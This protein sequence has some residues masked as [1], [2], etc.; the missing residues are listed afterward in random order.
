MFLLSSNGHVLCLSQGYESRINV[1]HSKTEMIEQVCDS[2]CA[3]SIA[4]MAFQPMT[5]YNWVICEQGRHGSESLTSLRWTC[6]KLRT[7]KPG[8]RLSLSASEILALLLW[9]PKPPRT[10]WPMIHTCKQN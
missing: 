10:K 6:I 9:Y 2:P 1:Y 5:L 4:L 8:K 3:F 7:F